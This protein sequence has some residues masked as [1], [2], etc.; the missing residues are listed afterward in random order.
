MGWWAEAALACVCLLLAAGVPV[1][2]VAVRHTVR[3]RRLRE[4]GDFREQYLGD[5]YRAPNTP[6]GD[7]SGG[8]AAE[9]EAE[10]A[11]R[12]A[13]KPVANTMEYANRKY[14]VDLDT[15][16][17]D[18]KVAEMLEKFDFT[19]SVVSDYYEKRG[20]WR[21]RADRRMVRAAIPFMVLS[22]CGFELL[23]TCG[24]G[25]E[26]TSPAWLCSLVF[27]GVISLQEVEQAGAFS[28]HAAVVAGFAFMGAYLF[29]LRMLMR[30]VT[31]YD[32]TP[33]TFLRAALNLLLSVTVVVVIFRSMPMAEAIGIG[34]GVAGQTQLVWYVV[35]FVLGFI[36]DAGLQFAVNKANEW[37]KML[38]TFD[39]S[40]GSVS[41]STPL[42]LID[43]IDYFVRFRLDEAN[44]SEMQNL[45]VAN[46]ILLCV[47]TPYTILQVLDW[48]AQAQLCTAVGPERFLILRQYN[49]RTVLD[50]EQAVLLA[51]EG[52]RMPLIVGGVLLKT[53]QTLRD[54]PKVEEPGN[55]ARLGA[56]EA[57]DARN[58]LSLS[59][60][61]AH[62]AGLVGGQ[63]LATVQHLVQMIMDDPPVR[64]LKAVI[65]GIH[66]GHAQPAGG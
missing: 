36:P 5:A 16:T 38:K 43:G 20:W 30:A 7:R 8:K 19:R 12:V 41:K 35:A 66:D 18:A 15:P 17:D 3:L 57:A 11:E 48:V 42:D 29:A 65:E 44:I 32:L 58:R 23:A 52:S 26:R 31:S 54:V 61:E 64:R 2:V 47:E 62:V 56:A 45:A 37:L 25:L 46:P 51:P 14:A 33:V 28:Q 59:E 9:T 55:F 40:F 13:R 1:A 34:S 22:F 53:T 4:L 10:R 27:R 49:I 39:L 50:L 21:L 24:L 6:G 60:Y 63:S